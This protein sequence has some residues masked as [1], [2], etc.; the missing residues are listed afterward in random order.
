MGYI[1]VFNK[2]LTS[3]GSDCN[4]IEVRRTE[5]GPFPSCVIYNA[6]VYIKNYRTGDSY[7]LKSFTIKTVNRIKEDVWNEMEQDILLWLFSDRD[8][9]IKNGI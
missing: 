3:L 1:N 5:R 7:I 4:L 6:A 9:I 2:F 8:N